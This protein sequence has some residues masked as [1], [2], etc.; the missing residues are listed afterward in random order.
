M[1]LKKCRRPKFDH[2]SENH[3]RFSLVAIDAQWDDEWNTSWQLLNILL[4]IS[5]N[6]YISEHK[7]AQYKMGTESLN[8]K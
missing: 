8:F 6:L 2:N 4:V 7:I 3:D 1:N 5:F